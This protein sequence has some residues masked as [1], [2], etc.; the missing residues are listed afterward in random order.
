MG[1]AAGLLSRTADFP[2]SVIADSNVDLTTAV[3][4]EGERLG[5]DLIGVA[6]AVSP[7]GFAHLESWIDRGLAGEMG[8]IPRRREAYRHPESVLTG[9]RSVIVTA[10]NYRTEEPP[11]EISAGKGRVSRYAWS[12]ADYHDVLRRKLQCLASY[13]HEVSPDSRTRAVVDTAPLL[14]RDFARLAGVGWFGKNTMLINKWRGSWLFLGA[15]LTDLELQPDA[16]HETAHCGTCTRCLEACPTDAF[17][18]PYVLDATKCISYLTI[19]LRD[20]PVPEDLRPGMG[21]WLF[22]CDVCQEVC[23]WNGK[24]PVST[25]QEFQPRPELA[26]AD[27]VALLGLS[28]VEFEQQFGHTPLARPGRDGIVRNACIVLGNT[29]DESVIA[30]LECSLSDDSPLVCEAAAWAIRQIRRRVRDAPVKDHGRDI[31]G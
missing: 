10:L 22:G 6:P 9:V 8:Y 13:L 27:C 31:E 5:F 30:A 25:T 12:D 15:L 21:D 1:C 16:P 20:Q 29:G 3:K 23:P 17:P 11:E 28:E 24:A 18:E 2:V 19:E 26:P 4:R 7:E 14:E